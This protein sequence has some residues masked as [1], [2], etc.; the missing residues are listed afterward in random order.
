MAVIER[1]ARSTSG[2]SCSQSFSG[3]V[4]AP[5]RQGSD[6]AAI[7]SQARSTSARGGSGSVACGEGRVSVPSTAT[8]APSMEPDDLQVWRCL[9]L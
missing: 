1:Q 6:V 4:L 5:Q 7:E 8:A 3:Q 2:H 9:R